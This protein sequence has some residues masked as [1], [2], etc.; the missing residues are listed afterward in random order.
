MPKLSDFLFGKREKVKKAKTITP[1]QEELMKLIEEGLKS[2][3][4]P[5]ADIFGPFNEQAFEK[6]VTQP[7]LKN[8][9]E[10]ILPQLQE[11]F[12][13]GNQVLGSGMRRAQTKAATDLQS[14]L[15]ELMYQ[16]QQG[17]QKNRLAGLDVGL[18]TKAFENIYRPQG[19]GIVQGGLKAGA[20]A[21]GAAAGGA[22]AG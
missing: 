7:A 18:G 22:V 5:F 11:K 17:Q 13:A 8:F 16:A 19:E 12:I 3:T 2:G 14:K 15:A 4:G 1:G 21:A 10:N 9:Q 6:G 20:G